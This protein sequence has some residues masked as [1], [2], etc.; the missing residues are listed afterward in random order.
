MDGGKS[1]GLDTKNFQT[2]LQ[3]LRTKIPTKFIS[4]A[5]PQQVWQGSNGDPVGSV[6]RAAGALDYLMLMNYDVWG[7]S[8]TPGPNAPLANL[9]GNSTQPVASAAGGVKAWTN[10]GMPASKILL[11]VPSYG[12]INTSTKKSLRQRNVGAFETEEKEEWPLKVNEQHIQRRKNTLTSMDGTTGSGQINFNQLVAQG[13]LKYDSD[14]DEYVQGDGWTKMW[15][16]CSD[17]PYLTNSKFI[18]TYDDPDSLYDKA[19]FARI[20][21]L[22]GV[23]MWSIDGD[24]SSRA[25]FKG[26]IA[27]LKATS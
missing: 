8:S 25:L 10:A 13:A 17:T 2:F 26:L 11:G 24:T 16:D 5:V 14:R 9:C 18:I 22:A 23:S 19:D 15:D 21:K 1:R 12:Y 4:A 20:G 6:A 7:S 3:L 27:G